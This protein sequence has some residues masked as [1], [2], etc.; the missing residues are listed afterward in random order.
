VLDLAKLTI[1]RQWH[2]RFIEFMPIGNNDLFAD[3]GWISSEQ[4]RQQIREKWGL[5]ASQVKGNG[6]ADVFQIPGAKGTLGF[7]SQMS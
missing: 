7:I 2:V 5:E 6:P 4:L 1:E 3:R